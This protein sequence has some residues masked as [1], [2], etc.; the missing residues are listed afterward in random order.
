MQWPRIRSVSLLGLFGVFGLAGCGDP[1][2]E[3]PAPTRVRVDAPAEPL[4]AAE[5]ASAGDGAGAA[6]AA[7]A[8]AA[9]DASATAHP[10]VRVT[11]VGIDVQGERVV[12]MAADGSLPPDAFGDGYEFPPVRAGLTA[13]LHATGSQRAIFE[14]SDDTTQ[15]LLVRLLFTAKQA[16]FGEYAIAQLSPAGTVS[17]AV[18]V[19]RPSVPEGGPPPPDDSGWL[20]IEITT[21]GL[22]VARHSAEGVATPQAYPSP[23]AAPI[24]DLAGE[25]KTEDPGA[26]RL[27]L[28]A[29]PEVPFSVVYAALTAGRGIACGTPGGECLLSDVVVPPAEAHAFD[30]SY[31]AIYEMRRGYQAAGG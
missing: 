31:K 4:S 3:K 18:P 2:P 30:P 9:S 19:G 8:A 28:S 15:G 29:E 1:T 16:G 22:T 7:A 12:T 13:A 20:S 14:V 24:G 5:A 10:T 27:V 17:P 26:H 6:P 25:L 23:E 11:A 21:T